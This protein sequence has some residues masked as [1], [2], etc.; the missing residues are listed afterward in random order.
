MDCRD[1]LEYFWGKSR[2]AFLID[3]M[4]SHYLLAGHGRVET[5]FYIP[6][7][8][9]SGGNDMELSTSGLSVQIL[10]VPQSVYYRLVCLCIS[11]A[12]VGAAEPV[13]TRRSS[14]HSF[15][16]DFTLKYDDEEETLEVQVD[17]M[18]ASKCLALVVTMLNKLDLHN[19]V[20]ELPEHGCMEYAEAK[21]RK[22]RPW[23]RLKRSGSILP[24]TPILS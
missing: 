16:Y 2:Y 19:V 12:P 15:G 11:H 7:L 24:E 5:K 14:Q 23:F 3:F 22:I 21:R 6:S 1:L 20:I 13:L 17:G 10:D 9:I 4:Q 18:N 8:L